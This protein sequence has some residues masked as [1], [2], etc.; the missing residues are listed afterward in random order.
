MTSPTETASD[1]QIMPENDQNVPRLSWHPD[2]TAVGS[3][4]EEPGA[5]GRADAEAP[6]TSS[7]SPAAGLG[8]APAA[9]AAAD[10]ARPGT[11]WP[12]IQAMFVDDPRSCLELAAGLVDDSVEHSSCPSGHSSNYCCTPGRQDK[13]MTREP[14]RY[15]P[16]SS[17][18]APS[19]T[20]SKISPVTS[21]RPLL[22]SASLGDWP[23]RGMARRGPSIVPVHVTKPRRLHD[24]SGPP[25]W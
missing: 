10:S 4:A 18:T 25:A 20:A 17:V 3:T 1:Q 6:V 5:T 12:E 15:A 19:G 7:P 16:R 23:G 2:V 14:R 13:A 24:T 21:E 22:A 9:P 11:R 8:T